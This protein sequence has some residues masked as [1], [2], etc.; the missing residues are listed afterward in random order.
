MTIE[1][2]I[3]YGKAGQKIVYR[4]DELGRPL[5]GLITRVKPTVPAQY[6]NA[7]NGECH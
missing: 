4:V 3:Y 7:G 6:A 1:I 2:R 5:A